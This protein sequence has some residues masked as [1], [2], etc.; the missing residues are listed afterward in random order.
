MNNWRSTRKRIE[1]CTLARSNFFTAKSIACTGG[2][3]S[4]RGGKGGGGGGREGGR[5]SYQSTGLK[6]NCDQNSAIELFDDKKIT[7]VCVGT[8]TYITNTTTSTKFQKQKLDTVNNT[9]LIHHWVYIYIYLQTLS[10]LIS[11]TTTTITTYCHNTL[12]SY[13]PPPPRKKK[14]HTLSW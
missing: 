10:L 9:L 7:C 12:D 14:T 4:K 13:T 8:H 2:E 3:R 11:T 6:K 1:N 5:R